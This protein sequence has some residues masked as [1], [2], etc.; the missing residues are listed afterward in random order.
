[1]YKNFVHAC[2]VY[3]LPLQI[4][5]PYVILEAVVNICTEYVPSWVCFTKKGFA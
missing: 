3:F 5:F 2:L 4:V 1:M